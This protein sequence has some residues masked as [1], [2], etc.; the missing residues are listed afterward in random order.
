MKRTLYEGSPIHKS[1]FLG[2]IR[3]GGVAKRSTGSGL[4]RGTG[5]GIR[6]AVRLDT[7]CSDLFEGFVLFIFYISLSKITSRRPTEKT[8][9][10]LARS[11]RKYGIGETVHSQG[12]G[13]LY[14]I[15]DGRRSTGWRLK[16][17]YST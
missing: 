17:N 4:L 14:S 11:H 5:K 10:G 1:D 8:Y 6:G 2:R 7:G 16:R 13:Y 12:G 3:Q 15:P 9:L